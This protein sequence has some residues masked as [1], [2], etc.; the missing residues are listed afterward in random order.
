[1]QSAALH[2]VLMKFC[3]FP[4]VFTNWTQY[5]R[6][7]SACKPKLHVNHGCIQTMDDPHIIPLWCDIHFWWQKY[8]RKHPD[9]VVLCENR[10]KMAKQW[11]MGNYLLGQSTEWYK[12][13][14]IVQVLSTRKFWY[15]T[16][17]PWTL[18]A[19]SAHRKDSHAVSHFME[20]WGLGEPL[21]VKD[22]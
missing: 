6:L 7:Q 20:L 2:A 4:C 13:N 22:Y 14:A 9:L 5:S 3:T 11:K 8:G 18:H 15:P 19:I 12:I 1:M 21:V 10:W 17:P 16:R